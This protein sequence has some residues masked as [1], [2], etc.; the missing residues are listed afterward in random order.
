MDFLQHCCYSGCTKLKESD[1]KKSI[2]VFSIAAFLAGT[3]FFQSCADK[4]SGAVFEL[5]VLATSDIHNNYMDYDYF[6]DKPS[7]KTGLVRI[8][9]EIERLRAGNPNVILV[10]DGDNIQGN[11]FGEYLYKNPPK[12]A[13]ISPVMALMNTVG[14]DA[15]SLGNHEFNFGLDYLEKVIKG[16]KFPV[17]CAN[18]VK[19]GTDKP[20]FKPYALEKYNFLDSNGKKQKIRVGFIGLVPPQIMMWD[21]VNLKDKVN[22]IDGVDAAEKYVKI[23]KEKEK[24][25]I[26]V[27]MAHSGLSDFS[28]NGGEENFSWYLTQIPGVD[29]VISG[30]SHMQFPGNGYAKLKGV[31]LEKGTLN[32]VPAV[33]PGS[34]AD[35][36]GIVKVQFKKEDGKWRRIDGSGRL[37]PLYNAD[38]KESFS[39]LES[40]VDLLKPTHDKVLAYIRAPVGAEEG[41]GTAGGSVSEPL[42]SF[43]SLVHDDFAVQLVNEAQIWYAKKVFTGTEYASLPILSAAAPF[44]CGGRQGPSYYTDIPAGPLAIKNMADLYVFTNT[45][46]ILKLNGGEIHEWLERSAGQFNQI[47]SGNSP[48]PLID[49]SFPTYL[50]DVIDGISYEI[51]VSAP[52]RYNNDG[53]LANPNAHRIVN[54]RYNG[55]SIDEKQE[56]VLVSNNYRANGGGN[57]PA[58]DPEHQIYTSPDENRQVILQYIESLGVVHPLTDTNWKLDLPKN[59]SNVT[60]ISSP[61]AQNALIPGVSFLELNADGFGVYKIDPA[62]LK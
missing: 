17:L 50:Y 9:S 42:N 21:A 28:R 19:A 33:M 14:Y 2:C 18:V 54:L 25:D 41:G 12:G 51:D 58:A 39:A 55:Q 24:A 47:K 61:K 3:L 59:A 36:L 5:T 20:Y 1:M 13:E 38:T 43:Y 15:M 62:T 52:K 6:T 7:D 48:Q 27:I 46:T 57:F 49:T 22:V 11:P 26:I 23:L 34:F 37:A 16:A 31:D 8:A 30:H 44:K 45:I 40:L 29:V 32:G 35:N 53:S 56:F 4:S 60:F 10:D